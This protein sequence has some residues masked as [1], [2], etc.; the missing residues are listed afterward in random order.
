MGDFTRSVGCWRLLACGAVFF[1]LA[2]VAEVRGEVRFAVPEA[3][4]TAIAIKLKDV[5][6]DEF[7]TSLTERFGID[8]QIRSALSAGNLNGAFNGRLSELLPR[9]LRGHDYLLVRGQQGL[10]GSDG[11]ERIVLLKSAKGNN[12]GLISRTSQAQ[13]PGDAVRSLNHLVPAQTATATSGAETASK[14]RPSAPSGDLQH[15]FEMG[16]SPENAGDPNRTNSYAS[17]EEQAQALVQQARE[18]VN[19]IA[20]R[21]HQVCVA[22]GRC[23]KV[24]EK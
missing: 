14:D 11:I 17:E 18:Q 9:I 12:A 23:D 1:T 4:N 3:R 7:L 19:R 16:L 15:A 24:P 22:S 20:D 2:Q 6:L 13:R 10:P 5:K 8:V 21:M